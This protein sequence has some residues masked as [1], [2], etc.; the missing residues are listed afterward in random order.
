ML[1]SNLI[2]I[3]SYA[4]YI[5]TEIITIFFKCTYLNL[6]KKTSAK[7]ISKMERYRKIL[8]LLFV[9]ISSPYN[10]ELTRF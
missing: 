4:K 6:K 10:Y 9:G 8:I 3:A 1:K 7:K 5:T 2:K